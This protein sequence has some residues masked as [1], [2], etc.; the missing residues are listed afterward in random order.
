MQP[1]LSGIILECG[2]V[3]G[4]GTEFVTV[5]VDSVG[6]YAEKTGNDT[7]VIDAETAKGKYSQF[8]IQYLRRWGDN[9]FIRLKQTVDILDIVRENV[10]ERII[11]HILKL[12]TL[13]LDDF[14]RLY[15]GEKFVGLTCRNLAF[16]HTVIILKTFDIA[17][18]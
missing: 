12:G 8:G 14:T 3:D 9:L 4:A 5:G 15:I 17:R 7:G 18:T 2:A 11:K 10:Q 6:G 13:F 1:Y 16:A